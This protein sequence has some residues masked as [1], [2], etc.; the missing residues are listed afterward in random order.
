MDFHVNFSI[1]QLTDAEERATSLEKQAAH[2]QLKHEDRNK[3]VSKRF[4][5]SPHPM[6]FIEGSLEGHHALQ[7]RL[8]NE[9][10]YTC[11]GLP[12]LLTLLLLG[13]RMVLYGV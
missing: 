5:P 11:S 7:A 4:P 6:E 3:E 10:K 12:I 1:L 8:G 13:Q 9:H 2:L